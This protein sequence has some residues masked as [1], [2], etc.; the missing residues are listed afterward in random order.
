M[1]SSSDE[2]I[3]FFFNLPNPTSRTIALRFTQSVTKMS[4]RKCLWRVKR[5]RSVKLTTSS[6]S[7][8]RLS[9]E[10]DAPAPLSPC[11][12][13]IGAKLFIFV[14]DENKSR[15]PGSIP[16]ATNFVDR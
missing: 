10:C 5:G 4:T 3:D 1:C 11:T 12:L 9:G 6:P 7:L 8:S 16:D 14:R 13:W 2:V 15:G